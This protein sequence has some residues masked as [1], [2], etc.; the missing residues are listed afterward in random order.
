MPAAEEAVV[1]GEGGGVRG[2]ED[3][4]IRI[5]QKRSF[6][7]RVRTPEEEYY[8]L[9]RRVE[10]LYDAV[11]EDLPTEGTV[12]LR[13]SL[14]DCEH[15]VEEKDSLLCP[16]GQLAVGRRLYA[17]VVLQLFKNILK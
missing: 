13:L 3:E 11:G 15:R 14:T 2:G 5:R 17:E 10:K 7:L 9:R 6:R 4:V 1:G 16:G 12:T 8:R